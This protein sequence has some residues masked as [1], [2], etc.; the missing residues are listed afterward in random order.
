MDANEKCLSVSVGCPGSLHDT[1]VYRYSKLFERI[2]R[3]EILTQPDSTANPLELGSEKGRNGP[4]KGEL[5]VQV[6]GSS[7]EL[8][9]P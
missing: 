1:R 5:A 6:K 2:E 3:G 7:A 4:A 9:Q 8:N